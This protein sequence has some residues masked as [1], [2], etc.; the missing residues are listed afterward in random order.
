MM[1]RDL[2]RKLQLY[3]NKNIKKSRSDV[4]LLFSFTKNVR[5]EF[6]PRHIYLLMLSLYLFSKINSI[7]PTILAC[8][9]F[10]LK[11]WEI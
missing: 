5:K 7:I 11:F 10:F 2:E 1:G 6:I 9:D 8:S 4:D 3:L